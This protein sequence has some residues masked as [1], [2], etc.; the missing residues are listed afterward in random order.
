MVVLG[1]PHMPQFD[2]SGQLT[3]TNTTL[4]NDCQPAGDLWIM[5]RSVTAR[6]WP[7]NPKVA[8]VDRPDHVGAFESSLI[9]VHPNTGP[10]IFKQP[11]DGGLT[12]IYGSHEGEYVVPTLLAVRSDD[13]GASLETLNHSNLGVVSTRNKLFRRVAQFHKRGSISHQPVGS[14]RTAKV[15]STFEDGT[16]EAVVDNFGVVRL[17]SRT[18]SPSEPA[19]LEEVKG[20]KRPPAIADCA[21]LYPVSG[22]EDHPTST[23]ELPDGSLRV[24]SRVSDGYE[25]T[26]LVPCWIRGL[27][28]SLGW[29]ISTTKCGK[30]HGVPSA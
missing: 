8:W 14:K 27:T 21:A 20:T 26:A 12:M 9:T 2:Q 16:E 28:V 5:P 24:V 30:G 19:R 22:F 25:V 18:K 15:I 23:A 1:T 10:V 4:L 6:F 11:R 3:N 29:A 13:E 7:F 17:A